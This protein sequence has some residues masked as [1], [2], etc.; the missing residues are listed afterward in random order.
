MRDDAHDGADTEGHVVLAGPMASGKTT[1]GR[2]LARALE[3]PFIDSDEQIA[4]LYGVTGRELAARDGVEALHS[5]EVAAL[6]RALGAEE[7]SVIA[8]AASVGD[9][10]TGLEALARSDVTLVLLESPVA[11]LM[12]RLDEPGT[13]R[14]PISANELASLSSR[15][16]RALNALGP[17]LV[18]DT[19]RSDPGTI[20]N[21]ILDA[22]GA[23]AD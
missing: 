9:S 7:P 13:H 21:Q 20:A 3:R 4:A 1:L 8:V 14:R 6:V 16:Q 19:S 22:L 2:F 10:P 12:Q 5:A 23:K 17:D 18:V 11:T 15:R